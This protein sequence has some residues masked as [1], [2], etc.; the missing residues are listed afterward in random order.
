MLNLAKVKI[1]FPVKQK[2][3]IQH[4]M[5]KKRS[6]L[7]PLIQQISP[8]Q[9][10]EPPSFHHLGMAGIHFSSYTTNR[11]HIA[12][13]YVHENLQSMKFTIAKQY[14]LET[15]FVLTFSGAETNDL[16]GVPASYAAVPFPDAKTRF[17]TPC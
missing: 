14:S 4:V 1:C 2:W 13:H 7:K 6:Q 12:I 17:K 3:L 15:M 11:F 16:Y 8:K 5:Q 10:A 9:I